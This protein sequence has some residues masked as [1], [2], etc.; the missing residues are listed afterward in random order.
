MHIVPST[1]AEATI[2]KLCLIFSTFG[3]PDQLVSDNGTGFTSAEF[4]TFLSANGIRQILTSPYHSSSNG[5]AERAKTFKQSVTKLEGSM[6][7]RL[8]KF[9]FK[10]RVTPHTTT[11]LSPA[12][13][14][15]GR[16][17]RTHLDLL[18]PDTASRMTK[19][20]EKNISGKVPRNSVLEKKYM[21]KTSMVISG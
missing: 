3:L 17:L 6:E 2:S 15:M 7:E 11:G 10:Y 13:L 20:I 8:T 4:R 14:L 19:K 1:S 5:L 9:L 12:E 21:L 16:R 18:H